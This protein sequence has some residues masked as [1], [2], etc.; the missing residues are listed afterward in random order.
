[1]AL[2]KSLGSPLKPIATQAVTVADG[3][4]LACQ[5]SCKNFKWKL[6]HCEFQSDMLIIPL[7]S[8]D[9]VLGVQWLC[10]LGTVN[11]DFKKLVMQFDY[12]GTHHTLQGMFSKG[13]KIVKGSE[14]LFNQSI[15][16]YYMQLASPHCDGLA[17][18][19]CD[20]ENHTTPQEV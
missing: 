8:C 11:W 14:N 12:K 10:E 3:N 15:Q 17:I 5:F 16:L 7:G 6:N 13:V 18:M 9:M 19:S 2:A 4:H 20:V 1:M